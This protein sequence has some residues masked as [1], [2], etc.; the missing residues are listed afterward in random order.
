MTP[1]HWFQ[2]FLTCILAVPA[3]VLSA[4]AL[5]DQQR[6][7][8]PRLK[9]IVGPVF[10]ANVTG[11]ESAVDDWP[12]VVVLNES[13][14]PLRVN[15]VGY[16]IGG[17]YCRFGRPVLENGKPPTTWPPEI[18]PRA[19]IALCLDLN[20]QMSTEGHHF[21]K[22][23]STALN[24]KPVWKAGRAYATTE[25]RREFKSKRLSRKSVEMLTKAP[26]VQAPQVLKEMPGSIK[27]QIAK[28]KPFRRSTS[29]K[30]PRIRRPLRF[31]HP[32]RIHF[33]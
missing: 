20:P 11:E 9:V 25:C 33:R 30:M 28:A 15:G 27:E 17:K 24:G 3:T 2:L 19:L 10:W 22:D 5:F 18:A 12:G 14:F 4:W 7:T 16:K 31:A 32:R 6:Q 1:E 26:K 23:A 13:T 29:Q 8:A 21:V